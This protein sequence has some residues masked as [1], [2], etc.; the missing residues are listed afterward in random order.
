MPKSTTR[1]PSGSSRRA[2]RWATSTPKASS[3]RK[4]LPMPAMRMRGWLM[5]PPGTPTMSKDKLQLVL[6]PDRPAQGGHRL[7]PVVGHPERVLAAQAEA[8]VVDEQFRR[9]PACGRVTPCS[10][11]WPSMRRPVLAAGDR[12]RP[13]P[14][15]A[16]NGSRGRWS[17]RALRSASGPR[18]P[19]GR[20][21]PTLSCNSS[22]SASTTSSS[23]RMRRRHR[24]ARSPVKSR[25]ANVGL[26]PR[27]E[28]IPAA[29]AWTV[30][31]LCPGSSL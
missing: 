3:P 28:S 18:S 25:T 23:A 26:W 8:V 24:V 10:D 13:R 22:E 11:S 15:A 19:C 21:A 31:R 4:M 14:S 29:N 27:N 17:S 16:W 1:T 20:S 7:D 5:A 6:Q 2:R 30:N 12:S 9:R